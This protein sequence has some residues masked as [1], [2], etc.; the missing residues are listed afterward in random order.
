MPSHDYEKQPAIFKPY[1]ILSAELDS[2]PILEGQYIITTDNGKQYLDI[3]SYTRL[4]LNQ[5]DNS[6]FKIFTWDGHGSVQE[7]GSHRPSWIDENILKIWQDVFNIV[8]NGGKA[9]V[10]VYNEWIIEH[11]FFTF[12][13]TSDTLKE[14]IGDAEY[15]HVVGSSLLLEDYN[16]YDEAQGGISTRYLQG[17]VYLNIKNEIV[18]KVSEMSYTMHYGNAYLPT[19]SAMAEN[20]IPEYDWQPT[21]KKYVDDKVPVDIYKFDNETTMNNTNPNNGDL[22]ILSGTSLLHPYGFKNTSNFVEI[23]ILN[24]IRQPINMNIP[25]GIYYFGSINTAITGTSNAV[26]T[27]NKET[28]KITIIAK[29]KNNVQ[30]TFIYQLNDLG[31]YYNLISGTVGKKKLFA[32]CNFNEYHLENNSEFS[33]NI[34]YYLK[35]YEIITEVYIYDSYALPRWKQLLNEGQR[36]ASLDYV[37]ST[38]IFTNL[39]GTTLHLTTNN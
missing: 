25:N 35:P 21:N 31:T 33:S 18:E 32:I 2:L 9:L 26:V 29:L 27:F 16:Y 28:D 24:E 8:Y 11:Q 20:F 23:E 39:E 22:G 6:E 14:T 4:E 34:A 30:E 3:D 1:K 12:Y 17:F 10:I 38:R 37:N 19:N 15:T 13:I 5:S 7:S 36:F